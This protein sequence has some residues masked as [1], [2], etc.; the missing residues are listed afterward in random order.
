MPAAPV[1]ATRRDVSQGPATHYPRDLQ[2]AID[3]RIE[4][5]SRQA[6]RI[7]GNRAFHPT[8]SDTRYY[9]FPTD[10][11]VR[12]YELWTDGTDWLAVDTLTVAGT[13]ISPAN[14]TLEPVNDGAPYQAIR[15][16]DTSTDGWSAGDSRWRAIQVDGTTGVSQATT[17]AG[18]LNG[19]ISDTTGTTVTVTD[20][21]AVDVGNII[22]VDSEWFLVTGRDWS[23]TAGITLSATLSDSTTSWEATVSTT[24][25]LVEGETIRVGFEEMLVKAIDSTANTVAL[26]RAVNGTPL[27]NHLAT[28]AVQQSVDLTVTRGALGSTAATHLDA[29]AVSTWDIPG[30]L[31][32]YVAAK[33]ITDLQQRFSA[34][35]RVVGQGEAQREH[36]AAGLA[37]AEKAFRREWKRPRLM[38]AV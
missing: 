28:A 12:S 14:Y 19:A 30:T 23:T 24:A 29:A 6:E 18:A 20:A 32:E 16:D 5:A 1:Y 31:R 3:E 9:D 37:G 4:A 13:V 17:T 26:D 21:Q 15:I 34:Y 35:A 36:K 2:Q 10:K 11:T 8:F 22:V 27:Q 33:A 25:G 7:A 38:G